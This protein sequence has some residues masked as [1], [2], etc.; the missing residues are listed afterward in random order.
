MTTGNVIET[1]RVPGALS[2]PLEALYGDSGIAFVYRQS[3]RRVVKQEVAAG[4]MNE[5]DVVV[6]RGLAEKDHVLMNAPSNPE[7]L[8]L[9]RLPAAPRAASRDTTRHAHPAPP[10]GQAS[11]RS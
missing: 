9:V 10:A 8:A 11:R 4:A 2:I 5:H 3:G 6:E 1:L 7:R